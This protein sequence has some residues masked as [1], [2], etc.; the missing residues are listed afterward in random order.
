MID[1]DENNNNK[2]NG[3]FGLKQNVA[4]WEGKKTK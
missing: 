3:R 2:K 1:W 4:V